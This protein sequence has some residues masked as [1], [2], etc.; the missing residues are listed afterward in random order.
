MTKLSKATEAITTIDITLDKGFNTQSIEEGIKDIEI[1]IAH[2]D[3]IINGL[4]D[5]VSYRLLKSQSI[6]LDQVK[7]KLDGYSK[8]LT[9]FN[10][11]IRKVQKDISYFINDPALRINPTDSILIKEFVQDYNKILDRWLKAN[12]A[13]KAKSLQI[14]RIESKIAVDYM[15]WQ[16]VLIIHKVS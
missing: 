1:R 16:S 8:R 10:H 12:S 15:R 9:K 3:S 4:E 7:I 13:N 6:F 2:A 14:A 11:D 5:H